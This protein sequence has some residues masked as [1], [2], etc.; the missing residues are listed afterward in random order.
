MRSR[1]QFGAALLLELLGGAMSLL[2]ATRDW[3]TVRTARER[4]LADDVLQVTGRTLDAA[5]TALALVALA[6]VVAVLATRGVVRRMIGGVIGAAGGLLVWRGLTGLGALSAQRA[7]DLVQSRHSGVGVDVTSL[8]RVTVHEQWPWLTAA[9]GALVLVAGALALARGHRWSAMSARY[10]APTAAPVA[11][12]DV[13][14]AR[15]RADAT[16][17]KALDSGDDPTAGP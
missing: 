17:W 3:Q 7:R 5:P 14:A 6:G 8:P 16:L 13:A 12:Q 2:L 15:S 9:C 10:E 4:P 11:P 1:T